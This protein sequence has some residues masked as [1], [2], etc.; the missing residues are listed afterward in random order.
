MLLERNGGGYSHNNAQYEEE[1][2]EVHLNLAVLKGNDGERGLP[3][4]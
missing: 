3:T 1:K 4:W 2:Q